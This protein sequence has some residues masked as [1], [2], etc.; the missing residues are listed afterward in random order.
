MGVR[1]AR[2]PALCHASI[3]LFPMPRSPDSMTRPELRASVA[4]AL[5]FALRMLGLFLI[6]PVFALEA[7]RM[8]GGDNATLVGLALGAY[9]LVQAVLQLPLGMASDRIGRKP[10]IVAGLLMFAAG[11]LVAATAQDVVGVL[12]GRAIQGAG[13][14]SA[15]CTALVADSTRESQRTKAMAM[16]G[17]S[18]GLSFAFTL[19][20]APWLHAWIGLD[21]LFEL[22]GALA[23]AA[24]AMVLW[25]VPPAPLRA[26]PVRVTPLRALLSDPDLLRLNIGV[27]VLHAVQIAFFIVLPGWLVERGGV[28]LREHG[29]LYLIA[30]TVSVVLMLAPLGWGER[31]GRMRVVFAGSVSLLIVVLLSLMFE[32]Q[33]L[34]PLVGLMALYLTAFNVLEASLPSLVSR[35]APADARG[36]ALGIYNTVQ[37]IG[38]F[39]GG[40]VG[41]WVFSRFG[42]PAVLAVCLMLGVVWL[43]AAV[44]QKRWPVSR[45]DP[46][47]AVSAAAVA[48]PAT[49]QS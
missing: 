14:I 21:G 28:P 49:R 48:A 11:S 6:L 19:V 38:M 46:S 26:Q 27:F 44:S 12:I 16:V 34:I 30:V 43:V 35:I 33:G 5:V 10:V 3:R 42:G 22:T 2:W 29:P 4:L 20:A 23:I 31:R 15:A 36:S 17:A 41:G 45:G 47:A 37:S 40:A 18:I 7:R 1:A 13:A 39:F 24:I 25:V 9:G 8:P 32:P